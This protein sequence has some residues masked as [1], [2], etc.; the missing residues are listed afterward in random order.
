MITTMT[1]EKEILA[2]NWLFFFVCIDDICGKRVNEKRANTWK[3]SC[4]QNIVVYERV[5]VDEKSPCDM[6]FAWLILVML[7]KMTSKQTLYIR[8]LLNSTHS[9]IFLLAWLMICLLTPVLI[10]F[11]SCFFLRIVFFFFFFKQILIEIN[12]LISMNFAILLLKIMD[13][14]Q[15]ILHQMLVVKVNMQGVLINR[16]HHLHIEI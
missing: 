5:K 8:C 4:S 16:P 3:G 9:K 7:F 11:F 1:G 12:D 14:D 10:W 13:L 2:S 15:Q 6:W